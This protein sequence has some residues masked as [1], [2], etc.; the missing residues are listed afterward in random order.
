MKNNEVLRIFFPKSCVGEK[1][2]VVRTLFDTFLEVDY[3]AETRMCNEICIEKNN[4]YIYMPDT[5]FSL[6]ERNWLKESTLPV[7]PLKTL[8]KKDIPLN[9]EKIV[10]PNLPIMYGTKDINISANKITLGLDIIGSSFFMLSRYEEIVKKCRDNHNRFPATASLAYQEGFLFRP[11][12]NEY[13]EIL[14]GCIQF[15]WPDLRRRKREFKM[16][17]S[18][19]V[20]YVYDCAAHDFFQQIKLIGGDL[21]KIR[22]KSALYRIKNYSKCARGIYAYDPYYK[23]LFW[24]MDVNEDANNKLM[25]Y[26]MAGHS[27]LEKDGCYTLDDSTV[28]DIMICIHNRGHNIGLHPSYN[29]YESIGQLSKEANN[30]RRVMFEE[31]IASNN[32]LNSRQHFLRWNP[33]FTPQIIKKAGISIDSTLTFADCAG[34]RCGVCYEYEFYDVI[35]RKRVGFI[36]SPLV[37][38]EATLFSKKYMGLNVESGVCKIEELKQ[39]CRRYE[40]DFTLLWHNSMLQE[41]IHK[42][43]YKK[44]VSKN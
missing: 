26:F 9:L 17:I 30:L 10:E 36:E 33:A 12:V 20:D 14:W 32:Q 41:P 1:L 21:I 8:K 35:H 27:D 39:K 25:F 29:T 2:W 5:F 24:M 19:D 42:E 11:I 28:R 23:N 16:R 31:K 15:L 40:G 37:V 6:A 7:Q 13:L 22:P 34:F 44:I 38:M 43:A 18:V 4:K 3:V